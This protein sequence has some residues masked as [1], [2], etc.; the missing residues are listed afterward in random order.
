MIVSLA[1]M[2]LLSWFQAAPET[3]PL[4]VVVAWDNSLSGTASFEIR[5]EATTRFLQGLA[6]DSSA[7]F[8]IIRF[9]DYVQLVRD[10]SVVGGG[11]RDALHE[12]EPD[13]RSCLFDC[14]MLTAA[15]LLSDRHGRRV[16]VV[17][18]DGEDNCGRTNRDAAVNALNRF[19][20][21]VYAVGIEGPPYPSNLG[22]LQALAE[23]TGG[24]YIHA[25]DNREALRD[26]YARI[27]TALAETNPKSRRPEDAGPPE[28][29]Q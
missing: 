26:A 20:V 2:F 27:R 23:R 22:N 25:D 17:A 24:L 11:I 18:T 13:G 8:A 1:S 19:H 15:D 3:V 7:A 29:P 28:P 6:S 12:Q 9:N 16:I 21:R 10:F 4:S 5:A 14:L